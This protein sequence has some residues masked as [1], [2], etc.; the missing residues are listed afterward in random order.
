[1]RRLWNCKFAVIDFRGNID[2]KVYAAILNRE[3]FYEL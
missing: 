1:M 3:D 2:H